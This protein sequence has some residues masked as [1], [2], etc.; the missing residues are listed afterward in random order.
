L[1]AQST[2]LLG[3]LSL[4]GTARN[5]VTKRHKTFHAVLDDFLPA[6][7]LCPAASHSD[8]YNYDYQSSRCEYRQNFHDS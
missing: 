5:G 1:L 8:G 7:L 4:N 2:E 3:I 6:S